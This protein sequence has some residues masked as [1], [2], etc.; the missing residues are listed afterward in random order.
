[1]STVLIVIDLPA[2]TRVAELEADLAR[3]ASKYGTNVERSADP[4]MPIHYTLRQQQKSPRVPN[5]SAYGR[6]K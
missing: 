4:R 3:L 6:I 1:M 5:N 2:G